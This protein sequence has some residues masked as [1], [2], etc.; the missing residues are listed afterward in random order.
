MASTTRDERTSLKLEALLEAA[1][2][3]NWDA[4]RGPK[5]LRTGRFRPSEASVGHARQDPRRATQPGVA[6]D[7]VS[8]RR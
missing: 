5:H 3:A 6:T 7:G 8:R 2:R 4:L 1:R